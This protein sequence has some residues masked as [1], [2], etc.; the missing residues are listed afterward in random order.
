MKTINLTESQIKEISEELSMGAKCFYHFLTGEIKVF[1]PN[2]SGEFGDFYEEEETLEYEDIW[3]NSELYYAFEPMTSRD[4]FQIM[5]DFVET[6]SDIG[7]ANRL[8]NALS[9]RKPFSHFKD[10][11]DN[12]KYRQDWFGFRD[13]SQKDWVKKQINRHNHYASFH[14]NDD[15]V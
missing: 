12:S 9:H 3:A 4:S 7:F 6:L 10:I 1:Y 11:V 5:E 14:E 15:E 8:V 2:E 13:E